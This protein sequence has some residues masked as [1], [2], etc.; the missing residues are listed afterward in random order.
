MR[1]PS[2]P[3]LKTSLGLW[4]RRHAHRLARLEVAQ[5][6]DDPKRV[7]KWY[8]LA[9]EAD[10]VIALRRSQIAAR[11]RKD[12]KKQVWMPGVRRL[13]RRSAGGWA[14]ACPPKGVIHTTEGSGDATGTLDAAGSH[15]HF[16]VEQNG[17]ITQYLPVDEAARALEHNGPP[18]TNRAHAIQIEVCGFA[19]KP[20]W[21]AEQKASVRKVMRFVEANAG[22]E[23]ASHVRFTGAKDVERL[24]GSAWLKLSGWCGHQHVPGNSH[25]DPGRISMGDLL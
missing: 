3:F 10:K 19:S 12:R 7:T 17:R 22:V 23:R 9:G 2:L 16:Q 5:A 13:P 14:V 11:R 25:W 6:E 8:R 18:E 20:N 24:S 4:E 21:P 1:V 15:P